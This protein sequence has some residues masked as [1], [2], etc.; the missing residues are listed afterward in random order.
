[1][2]PLA[3]MLLPRVRMHTAGLIALPVSLS[4]SLHTSSYLLYVC[5]CVCAGS[6]LDLCLSDVL[7]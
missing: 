2:E 6:H 1:M 3:H 7:A 5:V 4:V